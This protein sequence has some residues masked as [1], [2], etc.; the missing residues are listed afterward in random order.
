MLNE[1]WIE[2]CFQQ[3]VHPLEGTLPLRVGLVG[4]VLGKDDNCIYPIGLFEVCGGAA[5]YPPQTLNPTEEETM[6]AAALGLARLW[7]GAG[8]LTLRFAKQLDGSEFALAGA[9]E[10][11]SAEARHLLILRGLWNDGASFLRPE[12]PA[13][14]LLELPVV[15][16]SAGDTLYTAD[17]LRGALTQLPEQTRA[18]LTG[19]HDKFLRHDG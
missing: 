14:E 15:G 18:S 10:E 8:V 11:M 6:L 5:V 16:V 4:V 2:R 19:W 17:D 7:D 13:P 3:R 12:A 9:D 1:R